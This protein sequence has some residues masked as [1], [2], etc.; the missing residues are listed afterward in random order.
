MA[1]KCTQII[2][3]AQSWPGAGLMY[4]KKLF[5][6]STL[7]DA[8][9]CNFSVSYFITEDSC[10]V[11]DSGCPYGISIE[12]SQCGGESEVYS[13]SGCFNNESNAKLLLKKLSDYS[14]TPVLACDSIDILLGN[15]NFKY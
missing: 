13:A 6:S 4:T 2:N 12:K 1:V 11:S 15:C 10:T 8:D 5:C 9:G 7:K 3:P 14:V